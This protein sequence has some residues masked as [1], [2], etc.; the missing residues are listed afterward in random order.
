MGAVKEYLLEET[1]STNCECYD[2]LSC[3]TLLLGDD[4]EAPTCSECD[5]VG[6]CA[7]YCMGTCYEY[8][9][10]NWESDLLPEW[11][12]KVG[13]P[14]Y[15]KIEGKAMGW[16][17]REG[18]AVIP[19]DWKSLYGA[20]AI[21]GEYTL[22]MKIDGSAFTVVR[23]SHDEPTGATFTIEATIQEE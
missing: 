23:S 9:H 8:K 15:L 18:W 19:A 2:C 17:R 16:Q 12:A 21:N 13:N 3:G 22:R 4:G 10:E 14:D 11:L 20:L 1:F 5:L 7:D 6:V